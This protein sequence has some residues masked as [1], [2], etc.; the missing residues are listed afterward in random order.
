MQCNLRTTSARVEMNRLF[1]QAPLL[2]YRLVALLDAPQDNGLLA[3]LAPR[4]ITCL[5]LT[6]PQGWRL[7]QIASAGAPARRIALAIRWLKEHFAELLSI[8]SLARQVGICPSAL[9]FH[10]TGLTM[11]NPLQYQQRLRLQKARRLLGEGFDAR[12]PR[13]ASATRAGPR[14]AGSTVRP[15]A[16]CRARTSP[17]SRPKLSWRV[18]ADTEARWFDA[19][20]FRSTL[21]KAAKPISSDSHRRHDVTIYL[22]G[23][24]APATNESLPILHI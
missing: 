15:S 1:G 19:L 5:L 11:L 17:R 6:G 23:T 3:P 2:I 4:E 10:F 21:A 24:S 22:F 14:S 7:R 16:P 8:E 9:H 20:T 13:S 18:S 12:R